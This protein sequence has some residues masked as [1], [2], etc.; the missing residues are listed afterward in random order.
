MVDDTTLPFQFPAVGARSITPPSRDR[1]LTNA[2]EDTLA[3]LDAQRSAE[4]NLFN[5]TQG[6]WPTAK[7]PQTDGTR[8]SVDHLRLFEAAKVVKG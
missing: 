4:K 5:A 7:G 3:E 1:R 8:M 2:Q 6:S